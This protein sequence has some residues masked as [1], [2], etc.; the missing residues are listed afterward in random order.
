[1]ILPPSNEAYTVEVDGAYTIY[2]LRLHD[3]VTL[4][5]DLGGTTPG[6][7]ADQYAQLIVNGGVT[8][9][10]STLRATSRCMLACTAS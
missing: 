2:S 10:N 1:M 9:G 6:N 3:Q 7:E 4:R 5:F 8:L